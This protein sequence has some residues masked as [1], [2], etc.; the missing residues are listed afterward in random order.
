MFYTEDKLSQK[1][2][3]Y[4]LRVPLSRSET[5]QKIK[6]TW[7]KLDEKKWKCAGNFFSLL[8][9][10][11]SMTHVRL[12][13]ASVLRC[14]PCCKEIQLN[15][16]S[17][18]DTP[19][20]I[21]IVLLLQYLCSRSRFHRQ[22]GSGAGTR[23]HEGHSPAVVWKEDKRKIRNIQLHFIYPNWVG[24]TRGLTATAKVKST[25]KTQ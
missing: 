24:L 1:I 6:N 4:R 17:C 10:S 9:N 18:R 11:L 14:L 23:V 3:V 2:L 8:L 19:L 16:K 15:K 20:L 21:Y 25:N 7:R 13:K 12:F 5:T 22:K